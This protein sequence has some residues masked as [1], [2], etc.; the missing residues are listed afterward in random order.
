MKKIYYDQLDETLYVETLDNGLSVY[1]L[2]KH[3]FS[4]TYAT[5]TTRYGSIDHH[6]LP[7]GDQEVKVPD[8]IA[9]F[10]EHKMFEKEE[11]DVFT[12]FSNQGASANAFTSFT[13]T[14]YLFSST[15]HVYENL[16]T[17]VD[18]VQ[19]P[20]FTEKT[21]E[22]E[23]GIIG[24]E[25]RMYQD[26]PDWRVFFGLL[27][28]LYVH[29][30]VKIDIAGTIESIADIDKDLLYRCYRTF[31]H[32]SNMLLFVVGSV[33]PE[34]IFTMIKENQ[35]R[36]GFSSQ[37][38]VKRLFPDEPE[39]VSKPKS[40]VELHVGVPKCLIGI[41]D[42]V[43]GLNGEELLKRELELLILWDILIGPR[44]GLYQDLYDQGLID[45]SFSYDVTV[46]PEFAFSVIGGDTKDPDALATQVKDGIFRAL[47][48]GID[49]EEF[50]VSR[51]K[52]IGHF[53]RSLNSVEFIANQFTK[54]R[55]QES[56]LFRVIPVLEEMSHED[57]NRRLREHIVEE[58]LA[59]SVVKPAG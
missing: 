3:G 20:Y 7:A 48:Q 41:K 40:E 23:K 53:L 37:E 25:I 30:P 19:D 34:K 45:D 15:D 16:E 43:K 13:R 52:K 8:G 35:A 36:K 11:G 38:P 54:Y 4:K 29:H 55:F 33:E 51:N 42:S 21:V 32:P 47:N 26:N 31:Y 12:K 22:K 24:Q 46:E 27:D 6:F 5:F 57:V 9:H 10:L 2:P 39:K 50:E 1:V 44:S 18:F 59:V 58:R 17:L 14:S 49:A 56:D 28:N